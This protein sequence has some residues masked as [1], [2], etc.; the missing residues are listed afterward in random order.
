M[1]K[2]FLF[3]ILNFSLILAKPWETIT[4]FDNFNN[5]T[6]EISISKKS[7]YGYSVMQVVPNNNNIYTINLLTAN[8]IINKKKTI[9]ANFKVDDSNSFS[10]IG[11]ISRNGSLIIFY[12]TTLLV[13]KMKNGNNLKI[14][15]QD[16]ENNNLLYQFN[17]QNFKTALKKTKTKKDYEKQIAKNKKFE[18][19]IIS[20]NL[21]YNF[22][23]QYRIKIKVNI[24][25]NDYL[26][27]KL[28]KKLLLSENLYSKEYTTDNGDTYKYEK[29]IFEYYL[30]E[31]NF[32]TAPRKIIKLDSD[33]YF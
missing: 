1:K 26:L 32:K 28:S 6:G 9:N 22:R 14:S 31:D 29:I 8:K 33:Y 18:Y 16:F 15:I 5:P 12:D 11:H 20:H 19:E 10:L 4:M 24:V 17:I 25:D 21:Y 7:E 30:P 23:N 3:F 27:E 13:S 2:I